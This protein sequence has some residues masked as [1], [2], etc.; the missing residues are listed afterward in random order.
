[1]GRCRPGYKME[2]KGVRG[3]GHKGWEDM[4]GEEVIVRLVDGTE[5]RG[6]ISR[7]RF[8]GMTRSDTRGYARRMRFERGKGDPSGKD[9]EGHGLKRIELEV[10]DAQSKLLRAAADGGISIYIR[11]TAEDEVQGYPYRVRF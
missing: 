8:E 10:D 2:Q 9:T 7:V 3:H 6:H 5:A 1:V 11:L 4:Q